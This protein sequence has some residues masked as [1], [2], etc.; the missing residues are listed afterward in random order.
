[1]D[2]QLGDMLIH[3]DKTVAILVTAGPILILMQL[4]LLT[5]GL[6][7]LAKFGTSS[8]RGPDEEDEEE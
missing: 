5:R 8:L 4:P 2:L 6:K 1:M 3:L 7:K